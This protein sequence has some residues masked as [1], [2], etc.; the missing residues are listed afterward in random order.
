MESEGRGSSRMPHLLGSHTCGESSSSVV[1]ESTPLL[2]LVQRQVDDIW[3][4][5]RDDS[6]SLYYACTHV[7]YDDGY[8]VYDENL[9]VELLINHGYRVDAALA[10]LD[11]FVRSEDDKGRHPI[12]VMDEKK[13]Q[14]FSDI[15]RFKD[16]PK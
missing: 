8:P 3:R 2:E 13:S 9:L 5:V 1:A 14:I 16:I 4:R 6:I 12:V 7:L 10:W 15:E 11:Q